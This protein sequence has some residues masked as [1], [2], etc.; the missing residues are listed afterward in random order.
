MLEE[1]DLFVF[2]MGL[3]ECW[4]NTTDGAAYPLCPGTVAGQFDPEIHTMV[5]L[6]VAD[7]VADMTAFIDRFSTLNPTGKILLTVSPVALVATATDDHVLT[8]TVYS[9]SVLRAAAGELTRKYDNVHYLP[10]YEIITGAFNRGEY[11]AEDCRDVTEAGVNHVMRLFF[12]HV[13]NVD[14]GSAPP[15]PR[16]NDILREARKVVKA[17]CDEENLDAIAALP[18][19][20]AL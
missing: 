13:A 5:N 20:G 15:V 17:M 10:S 4:I 6:T 1:C 3:T 16:E 18:K 12:K 14:I 19:V 11:F 8:A 9:K 7:V 2:T